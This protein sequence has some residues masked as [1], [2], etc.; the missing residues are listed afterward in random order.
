MRQ[1][2]VELSCVILFSVCLFVSLC[3]KW[4]PMVRLGKLPCSASQKGLT[5]F[6]LDQLMLMDKALVLHVLVL[7]S[8]LRTVSH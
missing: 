5:F 4:W 7:W 6:C 1:G 2:W 8:V 3:W